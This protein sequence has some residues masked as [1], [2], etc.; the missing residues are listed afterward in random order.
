MSSSRGSISWKK[1]SRSLTTNSSR[2]RERSVRGVRESILDEYV[3]YKEDKTERFMTNMMKL[4]YI[5][6]NAKEISD[7][8][9]F[10]LPAESPESVLLPAQTHR[11]RAN[12]LR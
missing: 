2:P 3:V 8:L 11:I 6:K 12:R 10:E 9:D 5:I 1:H 4:D 7:I